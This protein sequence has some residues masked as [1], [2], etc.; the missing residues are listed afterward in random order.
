MKFAN[1]PIVFQHR[2]YRDLRRQLTIAAGKG[3]PQTDPRERLIVNCPDAVG[4]AVNCQLPS[5]HT[6]KYLPRHNTQS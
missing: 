5:L 2:S 3:E 6:I 1:E 4:G